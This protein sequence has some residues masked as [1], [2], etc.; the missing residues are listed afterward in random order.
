MSC[1]FLL[2]A[3]VAFPRRDSKQ[4][5]WQAEIAVGLYYTVEKKSKTEKTVHLFI[6]SSDWENN[7]WKIM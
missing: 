3:R 4:Q 6:S 7:V 5:V 1:W 2:V